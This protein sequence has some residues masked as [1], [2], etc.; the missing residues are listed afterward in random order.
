[1]IT[2]KDLVELTASMI[3]ND[4]EFGETL[5][6]RPTARELGLALVKANARCLRLVKKP[7][8]E[9]VAKALIEKLKL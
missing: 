2:N 4:V 3:I 1:M 8:S 6:D 7:T 5:E 9:E